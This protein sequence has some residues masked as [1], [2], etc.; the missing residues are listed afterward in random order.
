M[1]F[2]RTKLASHMKP[3]IIV[4]ILLLQ[5]Q[6]L[7]VAFSLSSSIEGWANKYMHESAQLA[8]KVIGQRIDLVLTGLEQVAQEVSLRL[9]QPDALKNCEALLA[10]HKATWNYHELF[11]LAPDGS[12]LI[13]AEHGF[14]KTSALAQRAFKEKRP[15]VGKGGL[16]NS[17]SY[18]IPV[19]HG[20]TVIAMLM[21]TRGTE[22]AQELLNV[23]VHDGGGLVILAD[24]DKR[25][26]VKAWNAPREELIKSVNFFTQDGRIDTSVFG[27]DYTLDSNHELS[28]KDSNHQEWRLSQRTS[29]EFGLTLIYAVPT[30]ALAEKL[31]SLRWQNSASNVVSFLLI[32]FLI[33][34]LL[35]LQRSYRKKLYEAEYGDPLTLGDNSAGFSHHMKN[36]LLFNWQSYALITMDINKF[37]LINDEYG[38]SK[39]NELLRLVYETISAR[40]VS[41]E[42]CARHNADT[43]LILMRCNEEQRVRERLEGI[44]AD[45][46]I[47]KHALGILHKHG[48][49]A[50]VYFVTDRTLPPY[51]MLDHANFARE[52]CKKPPYPTCVFYDESVQDKLR[53]ETEL[54]N[55]FPSA[56]EQCQFEIWLQ[57]KV[58]IH[59]NIVTGAEA[60]VRWR[61]PELGFLSPGAFL[62]V[63][64]QSKRIVQLD[65]WVFE[66]VCRLLFRWDQEGREIIP[67]A[68][69]L[70]RAHLSSENFL[71]DYLNILNVYNINPH[72]IELELTESL[73]IENEERLSHVFAS[74]RSHGL[75]CSID[76][77]G[78]GYSSLSMLKN[79]NVDTVKLDRS[80]F[81]T[82]ELSDQSRAVISSITQLA[83][84]LGLTTVAEGVEHSSTLEFLLSTDCA[85]VQGYLYSKPLPVPEF[86]AF[87]FTDDLRRKLLSGVM[88]SRT[89]HQLVQYNSLRSQQMRQLL[90]GLGHV[91][92]YVMR[93]NT[94]EILFCNPF[95]KSHTKGL[96]EGQF[97]HTVWPEYCGNCPITRVKDG[98]SPT[99][100]MPTS[101][102]GCP[103]SVTA[104]EILWEDRIPAYAITLVPLGLKE[105]EEEES[106]GHLLSQMADWMKKAREDSLTSLLSKASFESEVRSRLQEDSNGSLFFIDLDGFKQVNDHFGHQMGDE[107]LKGTAERIRLSFR[108]D[109]LIGR[110]GGDEFVVYATG[111]VNTDFLDSRLETLKNLL[112]HQHTLKGVSSGVSASIGVARFPEDAKTFPELIRKADI[113]LYEAKRRG[114]DQHV[115]YSDKLAPLD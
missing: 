81:S 10:K 35:W 79:A 108:R 85:T 32:L 38:V 80:F 107:V 43:F 97:C 100:T 13:P 75:R 20:D 74:I 68:V 101:S 9:Q 46:M 48:L 41:D 25:I 26:V 90:S 82:P 84:A 66:E 31:P 67:I 105:E 52:Q 39:A 73:F 40:L 49:S 59:T 47:R 94:R 28:F 87:T 12:E 78:T 92:V 71:N 99:F 5:A 53:F 30:E 69:N 7:Y 93:K 57:P 77:F 4:I 70:S 3:I 76:D 106:V 110:Y 51:I 103:V 16:D 22:K 19:F 54:L 112:R 56:L 102:F 24:Y 17:I 114:K 36:L 115:Y 2:M 15:A 86:E 61:H 1:Q 62:P 11:L 60:L 18:A 45:I 72:W 91:G 29:K 27:K 96:V 83:S 55:S 37:K 64:E 104:V 21:V 44:M 109:D 65:L 88:L 34:D 113:A 14:S 23:R 63:L 50:G 58:N 33:A 95:L 111:F 6:S 89:G 42:L 98:I 8:S